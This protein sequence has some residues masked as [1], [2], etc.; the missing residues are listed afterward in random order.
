MAKKENPCKGKKKG[1]KEL[2]TCQYNNKVI[3]Q[4]KYIRL[5]RKIKGKKTSLADMSGVNYTL[6]GQASRG[7]E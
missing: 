3:S 4:K 1:T 6:S 7:K 2:V 5:M